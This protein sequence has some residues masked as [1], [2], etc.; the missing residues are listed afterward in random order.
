MFN[1]SPRQTTPLSPLR[2]TRLGMSELSSDNVVAERHKINRQME[3]RT[4]AASLMTRE[5]PRLSHN[6]ER[7]LTVNSTDLLINTSPQTQREHSPILSQ[8]TPISTPL[9]RQQ[10][11]LDSVHDLT[12]RIKLLLQAL[13]LKIT[14]HVEHLDAKLAKY[15]C[16]PPQRLDQRLQ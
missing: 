5:S 12:T 10:Q 1:L 15:K 13:L 2:L 16:D 14:S 8:N 6:T 11:G 4:L 9:T 3:R 7:R